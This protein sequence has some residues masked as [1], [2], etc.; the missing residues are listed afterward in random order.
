[1]NNWENIK[2]CTDLQFFKK[3]VK[4]T[5]TSEIGY[6]LGMALGW[7]HWGTS[8]ISL[9]ITWIILIFGTYNFTK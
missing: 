6:I 9:N 1:M 3:N 5:E 7:N 2:I 4:R 8:G